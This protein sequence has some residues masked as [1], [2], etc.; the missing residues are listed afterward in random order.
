M[1]KTIEER[2]KE[3]EENELYKKSSSVHKNY[4]FKQFTLPDGKF[5]EGQQ[6]RE[7][8]EKGNVNGEPEFDPGTKRMVIFNFVEGVITDDDNLPAIQY[9]GHWEYWHNGMITKV[10]DKGGDTEEIW[11][12]GVPISIETG[13]AAAK[14][15]K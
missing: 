9:P 6:L 5:V 1:E 2:L 13:L 14:K 12:N 15:N 11:E 7:E 8:D 3:I 4:Q 10:V